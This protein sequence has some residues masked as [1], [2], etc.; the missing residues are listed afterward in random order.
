MDGARRETT[1]LVGD[2][3]IRG[4]DEEERH[5]TRK[6]AS[7]VTPR[8]RLQGETKRNSSRAVS[9]QCRARCHSSCVLFPRVSSILGLLVLPRSPPLNDPDPTD[10]HPLCNP[11]AGLL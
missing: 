10:R 1:H 4:E 8:E 11:L 6:G 5:R 3:G 7:R 9:C 2:T